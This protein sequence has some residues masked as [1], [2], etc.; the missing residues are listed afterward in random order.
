[1]KKGHEDAARQVRRCG[2]DSGGGANVSAG[3]E[4]KKY[5]EKDPLPVA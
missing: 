5:I 3:I 2:R 4:E 1:M